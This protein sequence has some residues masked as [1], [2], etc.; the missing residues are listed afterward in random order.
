[1]TGGATAVLVFTTR[2]DGDLAVGGDADELARRRARI[3]DAPWTWLHQ[4][5]GADVVDVRVP[6]DHAGD[7]AD[8]A[9]TRQPRAPLAVHAAD[10]APVALV[11]DRAIGVVHAGW[12]GIVSGVLANTVDALR[13]AGETSV[14]A[15]LGPCI[16]PLHYEFGADDLDRVAAV[17]GDEVRG[18]TSSGTPALDVPA[19]VR[20]A[21]TRA[22]VT[23]LDDLGLST[24]DAERF[25][26]HRLRAERGRHA[27]V[28]WIEP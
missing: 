6:G 8:A 7:D 11:G 15:V 18:V 9:I 28:A 3:V 17:L 14:R 12:R 22:G 4:V 1:M 27:L 10:C 24:A 5:H 16:R 20:V 21:L 2:A 13:D 25:F 23:E 19:A 26:S